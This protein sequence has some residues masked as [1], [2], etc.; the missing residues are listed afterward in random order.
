MRLIALDIGDKVIADPFV[1]DELAALGR[2]FPH[3]PVALLSARD[4]EASAAMRR[5][6]RG[7][8]HCRSRL[9]SLSP[10][11]GLF[12]LRASTGRCRSTLDQ[13]NPSS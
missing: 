3:A 4:E 13:M 7:F 9:R 2:F 5:G 12:L 1:D 11:C 10:A 6:I 8:S